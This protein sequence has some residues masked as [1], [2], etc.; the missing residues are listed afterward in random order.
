[1]ALSTRL[2]KSKILNS[3]QRWLSVRSNLE[4]AVAVLELI[5]NEEEIKTKTNL[6]HISSTISKV[7]K[8]R[9][10]VF[11]YLHS[12]TIYSFGESKS[13]CLLVLLCT[14]PKYCWSTGRSSTECICEKG[15]LLV[16][17]SVAQI[18]VLTNARLQDCKRIIKLLWDDRK[19]RREIER[20]IRKIWWGWHVVFSF[21][22]LL[23]AGFGL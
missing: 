6:P 5:P 17:R 3:L 13:C 20:N 22:I 1:M 18:T 8:V 12:L 23:E 4:L 16:W 21:S 10:V 15:S 9:E 19:N 7:M 2:I 11:K 14:A